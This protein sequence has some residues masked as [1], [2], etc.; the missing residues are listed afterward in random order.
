MYI[1][2]CMPARGKVLVQRYAEAMLMHKLSGDVL[3]ADQTRLESNF[4]D[5][6]AEW[7]NFF[8]GRTL[9][10]GLVGARLTTQSLPA[11]HCVETT[12]IKLPHETKVAGFN[13]TTTP[14][15]AARQRSY[16]R[17]VYANM[18][19]RGWEGPLFDY[20][21]DEPSGCGSGDP[22]V[23]VQRWQI[24][25]DRAQL[26]HEADPRIR[27][28]VTAEIEVVK[29]AHPMLVDSIDI[30]CPTINTL[31][32]RGSHASCTMMGSV[33]EKNF[34]K[35][36]TTIG[37]YRDVKFLWMYQACPSVGCGGQG[38]GN[39]TDD[40]DPGKGVHS[41]C[42]EGW[43]AFFAIDHPAVSQR[44]MQWADFANNVTGELY[45]GVLGQFG[46]VKHLLPKPDPALLWKDQWTNGANG[47]GN[48]FYP[49]A[50]EIISGKTHVPVESLRLKFLRDGVEDFDLMR[51]AERH[52]GRHAV[53]QLIRPSFVNLGDWTRDA[54]I[55]L[56]T[57]RALGK[58][59]TAALEMDD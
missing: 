43:P 46:R 36:V 17:T 45:W 29:A 54:E 11:P 50:P 25:H 26:V 40:K 28:M 53:L 47:D 19:Q 32:G 9:P 7:G 41:A 20:T 14:A 31:D 12:P 44:I 10:F 56:T 4:D 5:W 42:I 22:Q 13:C 48:L 15:R 27:N 24:L 51:I 6:A 16:W 21:V 23:C 59:V 37:D 57:R 55:L 52:L 18:K 8:S 35:N 38:C 30:W 58:A 1:A 39:A 2:R 49:G 33:N 3:Q 34:P